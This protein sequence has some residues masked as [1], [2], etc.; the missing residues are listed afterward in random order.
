[1]QADQ[2]WF[3]KLGE[4]LKE[5]IPTEITLVNGA[6]PATGSDYFSFCFPL[7]ISTESDLVIVELAINDQG[8]PEHVE[9][10]ENLI[11]GLLDLPNKPAVILAEAIAFSNGGMGGGGGRMHLQ[12]G[13]QTVN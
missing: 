13:S 2:I 11:R 10:M 9:N 6:A 1:M 5:F 4:W 8:I 3:Q 7:H 12:V